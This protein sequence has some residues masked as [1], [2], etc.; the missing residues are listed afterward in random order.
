MW[1]ALVLTSDS[2]YFRA[3]AATGSLGLTLPNEEEAWLQYRE[4]VMYGYYM[5]GITRRVDPPIPAGHEK[6]Y[7]VYIPFSQV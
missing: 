4:A 5:W 7:C 6:R 3:W 1:P 2:M